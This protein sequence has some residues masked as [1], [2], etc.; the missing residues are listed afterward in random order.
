MAPQLGGLRAGQPR[1]GGRPGR[2]REVRRGR[3]QRPLRL[4]QPDQQRA[5][6]PRRLPRAARRAGHARSRIDMLLKAAYAIAH[7]VKDDELNPNFIIPS[8][9]NADVP[10]AVAAAIRGAEA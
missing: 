3:R 2:R 9:F 6:V 10:K 7:V 1:P 8:V 4:P 5:R